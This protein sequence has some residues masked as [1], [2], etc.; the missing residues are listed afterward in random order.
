MIAT[1]V[2]MPQMY[3]GAAQPVCKICSLEKAVRYYGDLDGNGEIT[4]TDLSALN[5]AINGRIKLTEDEKKRADLN[6]DGK[7]TK[8]DRDL[9]VQF[10]SEEIYEFPV[11]SQHTPTDV[12]TGPSKKTYTLTYDANGGNGAPEPKAAEVNSEVVIS[13]LVPKKYYTVYL[14]ANGGSVETGSIQVKAKFIGWNTR[15]DGTGQNYLASAPF[16]LVDNTTLYARYESNQ[17]G[18]KFG[19]LPTPY[20]TGYTF[21]GWYYGGLKVSA[22]M[23]IGS[24]CTFTASWEKNQNIQTLVSLIEITA[25][26]YKTTYMV[27]EPLQTDGMVV[28]AR[29][30]DGTSKRITEYKVSGS[31][32]VPGRQ[33]VQV[34]YT[35]VGVTQK[36]YFYIQVNSRPVE[37][38]TLTYDA[39]GGSRAPGAQ[40]AEINSKIVLSTMIPEKYYAVSFN[41]NGGFIEEERVRVKAKFVGW[42]T[43]KSGKGKNYLPG[44]TFSMSADTTLYA[45]YEGGCLGDT[46]MPFK[47]GYTFKGWY[48][49]NSKVTANTKIEKDCS[50][51]AR[52]EKDTHKHTP[53]EWMTIAEATATEYGIEIKECTECGVV[54]QENII[55]MLIENNDEQD[56]IIEPDND[57][58]ENDSGNHQISGGEDI[59]VDSEPSDEDTVLNNGGLDEIIETDSDQNHTQPD[60]DNLNLGQDMSD[61]D[62]V[63]DD[64]PYKGHE[65]E[66]VENGGHKNGNSENEDDEYWDDGYAVE[67][68]VLS[69]V[70]QKGKSTSAVKAYVTGDDEIVKYKSSNTS[71]VKVSALGKIQAKKVGKAVVT[72]VTK[73]G[74]RAVVRIKVQKK[75]V[76]TKKITVNK[77]KIKLIPGKI[78]CLETAVSPVT[79][80]QK[81]RYMSSNPK[82]VVVNKTGKIKAKKKGTAV[83]KIKSG[84]KA[85]KLKVFVNE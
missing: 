73:R 54:M 68:N 47:D 23:T 27:G 28:T 38:K 57:Q 42:N 8:E 26:P 3:V 84:K 34:S 17:L 41:V 45:C 58:N 52:W 63:R 48:Y 67:W 30:S 80:T 56:I 32:D 69:A 37:K 64:D 65:N 4:A 70:L 35:E 50:L 39:N 55:P 74:N 16:K 14:D 29:Y 18:N 83:I 49:G 59:M 51:T 25:D 66:D 1:A 31:T 77:K 13:Q 82:V 12:T 33:Q 36:T 81:I 24:N 60:D 71:V 2:M 75:A 61:M 20:K 21:K 43:S 44:T 79:S 7:I 5:Q 53:G 78:F 76:T 15:K 46:P 9:M 6:G 10:I 62:N 19:N 11:E 72:A 85:V 22:N 40:T